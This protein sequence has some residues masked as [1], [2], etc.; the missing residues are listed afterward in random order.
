MPGSK[1]H[2]TDLNAPPPSAYPRDEVVHHYHDFTPP[3]DGELTDADA[4]R[5]REIAIAD[6][7]VAAL[8]GRGKHVAIGG[9][10][11]T[12]KGETESPV[13][14]VFYSYPLAVA[15]EAVVDLRA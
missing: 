7:R 8:L 11:P 15:I 13:T 6:P 1:R 14:Y 10:R 5:A 2:Q 4:E 9:T 12:V 3:H